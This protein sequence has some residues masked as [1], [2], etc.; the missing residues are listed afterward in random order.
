MKK[1]KSYE[2][3]NVVYD[4]SAEE[5]AEKFGM[6]V[7]TVRTDAKKGKLP[8]VRLGSTYLF[9]MD[10]VKAVLVRVHDTIASDAAD[11]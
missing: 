4:I 8:H 7:T 6:H 2:H 3:N 11:V 5:I 1:K 9:N 10:Q